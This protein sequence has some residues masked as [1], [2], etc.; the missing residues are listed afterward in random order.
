[1]AI[2]QKASGR[3][4]A[5]R[6]GLAISAVMVAIFALM[7]VEAVQL[8]QGARFAP[9]AIG[10]PALILALAQLSVEIRA[11]SARSRLADDAAWCVRQAERR[12]ESGRALVL[13]GWFAAIVVLALVF[14]V[15][16]A[17]PVSVF[18]FLRWH[19][20]DQMRMVV[21]IAAG[22]TAIIFGVFDQLMGLHLWAGILPSMV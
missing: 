2:D 9:L 15:L 11:L 5:N 22:F 8:R 17:F 4:G 7:I 10:I 21:A 1:M 14:G 19:Q 3:T 18:G 16:I 12:Q 20:K 6:A 13:I